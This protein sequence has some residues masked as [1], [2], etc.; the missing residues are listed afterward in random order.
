MTLRDCDNVPLLFQKIFPDNQI[1]R[2]F[3]ISKNKVLYV[4]QD[5]LGSLLANCLCKS[6]SDSEMAFSFM[7]DEATNN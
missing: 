3:I 5:G 1:A 6:V 4:L 2:E 7:F